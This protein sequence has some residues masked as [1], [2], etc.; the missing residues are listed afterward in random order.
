QSQ[1]LPTKRPLPARIE[2]QSHQTRRA[3][4]T[5][6][7]GHFLARL[8]EAGGAPSK[9]RFGAR[10]SRRTSR[11]RLHARPALPAHAP[12]LMAVREQHESVTFADLVPGAFAARFAKIDDSAALVADQMIVVVPR[13]HPLVAIALL[14]D[15][16]AADDSGVDQEVERAVDRR[17]GDLLVVCPQ[18]HE[19]LVRLQ[20]LMT[21]KELV[22]HRQPFGGQ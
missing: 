5:S 16:N 22:E 3:R 21:R 11:L 10:R 6:R 8:A 1:Q 15:A 4:P 17:P 12:K 13:A 9:R 14:P 20:V 19:Q 18:A 7:E 2:T